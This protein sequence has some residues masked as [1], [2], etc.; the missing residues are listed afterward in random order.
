[1]RYADGPSVEVEV[2]VHA[3]IERVWALVADLDLPARYSSEFRGA[4]W[5]D[6]PGLGARFVGR[7]EHPALGSWETTSWVTRYEPPH[8]FAWSVSDRDEPSATWWFELEEVD[9]VDGGPR[10][11]LRQGGRMGPAPSGLSIAIAAKPDNEE[12][13]VAPPLEEWRTNLLATLDGVKAL[14][15]RGTDT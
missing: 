9:G 6:E 15:E 2:V 11:R 7:N 5:L 1:V 4:T 10:V 14:A 3:P 13:I 12:R 8:A